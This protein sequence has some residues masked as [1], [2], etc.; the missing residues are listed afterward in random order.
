MQ[1][2]LPDQTW[3]HDPLFNRLDADQFPEVPDAEFLRQLQFQLFDT[4]VL[5]EAVWMRDVARW[6]APG[7]TLDARVADWL[8]QLEAERGADHRQLVEEAFRLFDWTVRNVQLDATE[9]SQPGEPLPNEGATLAQ[10]RAADGVQYAWEALLLGHGDYIE[11]ARV[12]I[13]LTRQRGIPAV[14][15]GVDDP[16]HD[17]ERPWVVATLI[18]NQL[19]LFD[20]RLGLPV[21]GPDGAAVATLA[22]VLEQPELVTGLYADDPSR[23]GASSTDLQRLVALIDA[24]PT[25]LSQ[26]MKMIESQLSGDRRVVLSVA[27]T[28]FRRQLEELPGVAQVRLWL[29]PYFGYRYHREL[30]NHPELAAELA[31]E[32]FPFEQHTP[33]AQARILH[34]RGRFDPEEGLGGAKHFYLETRISNAQIA[35][36]RDQLVNAPLPK[37]IEQSGLTEAELQQV[38][39]RIRVQRQAAAEVAQA[40]ARTSKSAASYWLGLLSFDE[41]EFRVAAD[42][43]GKRVLE[44]D[45]ESRWHTGARY[46]LARALEQ[47]VANEHEGVTWDEVWE[48]LEGERDPAD[49]QQFGNRKRAQ[50]MRAWMAAP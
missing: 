46:N 24:T 21:P 19:Y 8:P 26:R 20:T 23:L 11:R 17:F 6:V 16:A 43:L 49:P 18:D 10:M 27:A 25:Y 7:P 22:E 40:V 44:Q 32:S 30:G 4:Y 38:K 45:T 34:F 3:Q 48:L 12:L 39:D 1:T 5:Q 14:M 42:Y 13:L 37:E 29:Q 9:S 31:G 35:E 47:R 33:L 28:P 41:Q 2:Q 36:M 15:L 50:L